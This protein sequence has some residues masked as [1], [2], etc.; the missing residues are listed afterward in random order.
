MTAPLQFGAA[1]SISDRMMLVH[2]FG[3][4]T[5]VLMPMERIEP[6]FSDLLA[7]E[8]WLPAERALWMTALDMARRAAQTIEQLAST[9]Q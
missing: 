4:S 9:Q 7:K 2:V 6:F 5:S 8:E 1:V 3:G